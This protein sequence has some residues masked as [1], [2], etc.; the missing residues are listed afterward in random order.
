VTRFASILREKKARAIKGLVLQSEV[1]MK[2][3]DNVH[4]RVIGNEGHTIKKLDRFSKKDV[5][6]LS[7]QCPP[8]QYSP[9]GYY[10]HVNASFTSVNIFVNRVLKI[11]VRP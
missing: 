2:F 4:F 11:R 7:R 1:L 3:L 5:T 9:T 6:E 10:T 8:S